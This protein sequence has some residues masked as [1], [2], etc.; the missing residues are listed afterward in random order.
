MKKVIL[1]LMV[2]GELL[3]GQCISG[4]CSNGYS[5]YVYGNGDKYKGNF[6]DHKRDGGG[7]YFYAN[8]EK[9]VGVFKN[10]YPFK[11]IFIK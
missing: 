6:K 2:V 8:G 1:F 9:Y 5:F 11:T 3:V 10:T 7:I 4:N